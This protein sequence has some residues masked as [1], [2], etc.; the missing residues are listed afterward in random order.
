MVSGRIVGTWVRQDIKLPHFPVLDY[1]ITFLSFALS[2][3]APGIVNTFRVLINI[4]LECFRFPLKHV[5][6]V[7]CHIPG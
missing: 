3:S 2:F 1:M 4:S 7:Y 6:R 5:F